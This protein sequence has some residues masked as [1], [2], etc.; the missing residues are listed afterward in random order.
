[1]GD[2]HDE[3]FLLFLESKSSPHRPIDP[4][5]SESDQCQKGDALAEIFGEVF[6]FCSLDLVPLLL[7]RG[8]L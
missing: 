4:G 2:G 5:G 6:L 8:L 1:M 3:F 7:E